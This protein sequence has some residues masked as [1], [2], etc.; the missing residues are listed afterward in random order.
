MLRKGHQVTILLGVVLWVVGCGTVS[1]HDNYPT[2]MLSPFLFRPSLCAPFIGFFLISCYRPVKVIR[3]VTRHS[4]EEI[5]L[6]RAMA[7]LQMTSTVIEGG[8]VSVGD[9]CITLLQRISSL[10]FTHGTVSSVA[11]DSAQLS[12]IL[13]FGLD[14]LLQS[15]ER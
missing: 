11:S 13:K 6:K 4:V 9:L 8:Q 15:E 5:V 2:S 7:K 12:D 3:L 10:Q 14:N 1:T